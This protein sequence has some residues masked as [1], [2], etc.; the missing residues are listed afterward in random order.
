MRGDTRQCQRWL[1]DWEGEGRIH[2]KQCEDC[3]ATRELLAI[4][5]QD[6]NGHGAFAP[7]DDLAERRLI[8]SVIASHEASLDQSTDALTSARGRGTLVTRKTALIAVTTLAAAAIT[9]ILFITPSR[10]PSPVPSSSPAPADDNSAPQILSGARFARVT[11]DV[12]AGGLASRD[13]MS[14]P[15]EVPIRSSSGSYV[16]ALP[17]EIAFSAGPGS[18][19]IVTENPERGLTVAISQGQFVFSVAPGV[20]RTG[21]RVTTSAGEIRLL[22]TV[23]TVTADQNETRVTVHRGTVEAQPHHGQSLEVHTHQSFTMNRAELL[24]MDRARE[25]ALVPMM[26]EIEQLGLGDLSQPLTLLQAERDIASTETDGVESE[27]PSEESSRIRTREKPPTPSLKMLIKVGRRAKLQKNWRE[28]ADAYGQ[29][30]LY[31]PSSNDA[32]TVRVTL[33][34]LLLDRLHRPKAALSHLSRYLREN[35]KGP[36]VPEALYSS[37]RCHRQLRNWKAERRLLKKL[38]SNY[39]KG[40]HAGLAQKRL[41]ELD[42]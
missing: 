13:D 17:S 23:F 36:L 6:E 9:L 34:Q 8:D 5:G 14:L 2:L 3:L 20:A 15:L 28:A 7:L 30:L 21:F 32:D 35:P 29:I 11:G 19:L 1:D 42:L 38:L 37:A 27:A 33:G 41:A 24:P 16:I 12:S 40:L 10:G 22:G 25:E 31:Y 26:Q 39:P 4:A 18:E